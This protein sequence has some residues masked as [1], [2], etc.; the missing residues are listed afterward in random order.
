[1]AHLKV[2]QIGDPAAA[3]KRKSRCDGRVAGGVS[4]DAEAVSWSVDCCGGAGAE[5]VCYG[6]G[7]ERD[8]LA[9]GPVT[10]ISFGW[11]MSYEMLVSSPDA[12]L[13]NRFGRDGMGVKSNDSLPGL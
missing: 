6:A 12:I 8:S 4:G 1:M 13:R 9:G 5:S 2:D 11:R 7:D 3:R 10:A